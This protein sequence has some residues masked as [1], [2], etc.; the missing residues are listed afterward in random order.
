M[1][2]FRRDTD[3]GNAR[4][5]YIFHNDC[6]GANP[7]VVS[8]SNA[9]DNLGVLSDVHV[10]PDDGG[11]VRIAAVAADA[12]V[13]V[14]DASFADARLGVH[15]HGTEVLQVKVFTE[16]AGTDDKAQS[17]AEAILSSA[18]PEA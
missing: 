3:N 12:A 1:N 11:V 7:D 6:T 15:N 16:A 13:T 9:T 14:D 10:V 8:N 17:G 18:V 4:S 2:F 5:R